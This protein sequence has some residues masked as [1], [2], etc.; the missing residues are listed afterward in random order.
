MQYRAIIMTLFSF[1]TKPQSESKPSQRPKAL[2]I[3]SAFLKKQK[4]H[5]GQFSLEKK[6]HLIQQPTT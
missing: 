5:R 6:N 3:L 2:F 4:Q 1:Y